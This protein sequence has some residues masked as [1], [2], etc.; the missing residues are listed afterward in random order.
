MPFSQNA[1]VPPSGSVE[2]PFMPMTLAV[3]RTVS[4]QAMAPAEDQST[5]VT[6]AEYVFTPVGNP[7]V[8]RALEAYQRVMEMG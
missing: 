5:D 7:F 4:Y 2:R 8:R 6:D 3:V 1:L